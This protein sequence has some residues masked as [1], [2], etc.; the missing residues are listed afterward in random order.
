MHGIGRVWRVRV[1][2]GVFVGMAGWLAVGASGAW[3]APDPCGTSGVYSTSGQTAT[4]SYTSPGT[5]DIFSV[6]SYASQLNVTAIAAPGGAGNGGYPGGYGAVVTNSALPVPPASQ[7]YV[8]V[9]G[10]GP[11]RTNCSASAET[12]WSG[13]EFDG[14]GSTSNGPGC[15]AGGGGGGSSAVSVASVDEGAA[16]ET[17]DPTSDSRLLVAGG[18]GGGGADGQS[19]GG[20]AGSSSVVGAGDGSCFSSGAPGGV[21]GSSG[22]SGSPCGGGNGSAS[23]G[24]RGAPYGGGGGGGWLGGGGGGLGSGG[25]GGG[26]SYGGAGASS[27]ISVTTDTTGVPEVTISWT[28]AA[29]SISTSQQPASVVVGSSIAD[30]ATVSGGDSPTGT[31]T[32]DLYNNPNGTGTPLFSD[33]NEPLSNGTATSQG[34]TTT[35]AGTDYW[36]A[37]YN[38]DPTNNSVYSD[39]ADEPVTVSPASPTIATSQ[40]PASATVGTSIADQATVS[41]GDSPTGTVTFDL[42]NNPND[43]GTPLF[44]DP[45]EPLSN[46]TATSQGYTTTAAGTDYWVATYNGDVN[47]NAVSSGDADEPVTVTSTSKLADLRIAIT[48]PTQRVGW[49][50]L[51]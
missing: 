19:Y 30:Q 35:A 20:S 2:V 46:G 26:S 34:Y 38:G 24:G 39:G 15:F 33:P 28:L 49:E 25:G 22:G 48:G 12:F 7:L 37:T 4:C 47:N 8:D 11:S 32:F 23:G 14:G 16:N 18:G 29:P 17:G 6:P 3:A 51:Q 21:G 40:Q 43:T 44:S 5:E 1:P 9:G 45:N 41:G 31:V 10:P 36:V 42:Y 13:G 50:Q 27:G